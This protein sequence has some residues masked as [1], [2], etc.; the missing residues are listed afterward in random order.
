MSDALDFRPFA[1]VLPPARA[2]ALPWATVI[3]ASA[4]T[5]VPVV[6]TLPLMPPLGLL[7]LL[8]WRLLA[9]FALRRWA[10]APLGLFDDLVSGQ[11]L[12]SAVLSW[13]LC[14]L[15]ID[16][17]EQRFGDR[18]FAQD[19]LIAAGL[20]A[21]VLILGRVIAAPLAAPL[22][23]VLAAQIGASVLLFPAFARIVA[24]I[25]RRRTQGQIPGAPG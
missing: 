23:P 20:I 19:W 10:A 24:W 9:R 1:P 5:A 7:M 21:G 17:V 18:D 15:V 3:G 6:A 8:T 13:S 22:A 4:L 14:F 25:D 12:G 11:P 2:R 16:M